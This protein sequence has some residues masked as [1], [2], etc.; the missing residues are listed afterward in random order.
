MT[1]CYNTNDDRKRFADLCEYFAIFAVRLTT[2]TAKA[3]KY[4]QRSAKI[5]ILNGVGK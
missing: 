4:S 3:A 2:I 1:G 5:K